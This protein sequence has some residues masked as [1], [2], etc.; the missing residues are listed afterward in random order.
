MRHIKATLM[1]AWSMGTLALFTVAVCLPILLLPLFSHTGQSTFVMARIWSWLLLRT[2]FV[3]IQAEGLEK[4]R[5][6]RSYVFIANH[7]SHLDSPAMALALPNILRFVGKASLARIPVFGW[8]LRQTRA[9]IF[10][11]RSDP[12]RAIET[13]NRATEE[14]KGGVSALFYAEGTRSPGGRLQ[15]FKKG[16]VMLAI[17]AQLPMVPVTVVGSHRLLPKYQLHIHPGTIRVIVGDP[18]ETAGRTEADRDMLLETAQRTIQENLRQ[19]QFIVTGHPMPSTQF[20]R[21]MPS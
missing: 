19:D 9:A 12:Q 14:L 16:G 5:R 18:I 7:A 6:N 20:S 21:K 3:G 13:L 8:A 15:P 17:Q 10:I 2:N 1:G 11:D 4:I